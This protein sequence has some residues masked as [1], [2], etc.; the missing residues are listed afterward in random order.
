M[1]LGKIPRMSTMRGICRT[2]EQ[3]GLEFLEGEGIRRRD[4]S[5]MAL[6]GEAS[7]DDLF[8]D[9]RRVIERAEADVLVFT[10]AERLLTQKSGIRNLNILQRLEEIGDKAAVKCLLAGVAKASF[11]RPAFECRTIPHRSCGASFCLVYG[12]KYAHVL[13]DGGRDFIAVTYANAPAACAERA[14]FLFLWD[15]ALPVNG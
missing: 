9:I 11:P 3:H 2:I 7:C 10:K 5:V 14:D 15:Y 12:A 8:E 13:Q 6:R 4:N 1:E